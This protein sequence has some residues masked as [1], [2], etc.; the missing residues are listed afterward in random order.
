MRLN[1]S[2][3][4]RQTAT[5]VS[6]LGVQIMAQI[7]VTLT[8]IILLCMHIDSIQTILSRVVL[9]A[10]IRWKWRNLCDKRCVFRY[11]SSANLVLL[12]SSP[13][14]A[15]RCGA[16]CPPFFLFRIVSSFLL[17]HF[18]S[19]FTV[20]IN[21]MPFRMS[22]TTKDDQPLNLPSRLRACRWNAG[23]VV[24]E[25]IIGE[26]EMAGATQRRIFHWKNDTSNRIRICDKTAIYTIWYSVPH[27]TKNNGETH[28]LWK[29]V[30][31]SMRWMRANCECDTFHWK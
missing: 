16:S 19:V 25:I 8:I 7:M 26:I 5:A 30:H 29:M 4:S 18:L 10:A 22:N 27:R 20:A 2:A 24:N 11:Q 13:S 31:N 28:W 15:I 23:G 17:R 21:S 14:L 3:V 1:R 12:L 9:H 6:V